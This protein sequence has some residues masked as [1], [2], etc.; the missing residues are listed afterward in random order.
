LFVVLRAS[1]LYVEQLKPCNEA[2]SCCA[3]ART[4]ISLDITAFHHRVVQCVQAFSLLLLLADAPSFPR[5]AAALG[6]GTAREL[7]DL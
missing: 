6:E 2:I 7:G 4:Q 1:E 3:L 5:L